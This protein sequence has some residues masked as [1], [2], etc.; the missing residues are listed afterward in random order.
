VS[1]LRSVWVFE[2]SGFPLDV[3]HPEIMEP[4][5]SL[6][7]SG[8]V[9]VSLRPKFWET[10]DCQPHELSIA[11]CSRGDRLST[12]FCDWAAGSG[13]ASKVLRRINRE[14]LVQPTPFAE[15]GLPERT[16]FVAFALFNPIVQV[17][18]ECQVR[19]RGDGLGFR[20]SLPLKTSAFQTERSLA[21]Q[22]DV[23]SDAA[24]KYQYIYL[25]CR[26]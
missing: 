19:D 13:G 20:A 16:F 23:Q 8:E 10:V 1:S 6:F 2:G 12:I 18:W 7:A 14:P 26:A 22:P 21:R 17:F 3:L 5:L 9:S 25:F 11:A 15:D 24:L 4:D